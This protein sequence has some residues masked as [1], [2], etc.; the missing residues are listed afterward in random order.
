MDSADNKNTE[1]YYSLIAPFYDRVLGGF[2]DFAIKVMIGH[3]GNWI[4]E[5]EGRRLL[6]IGCG[7]GSFLIRMS[8]YGWIGSG[9]DKSAEMIEIARDKARNT[10]LKFYVRDMRDFNLNGRFDL[11]TCIFDSINYILNINDLREV[12]YNV[13]DHL[14][15]GSYFVF[16]FITPFHGMNFSGVQEESYKDFNFSINPEFDRQ[17]CIKTMN[18]EILYG[19]HRYSEVHKQRCYEIQEVTNLLE[20]TGFRIS[21]TINIYSQTE[22]S[23][24][25]EPTRVFFVVHKI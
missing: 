13:E 6:D 18:I 15:K 24:S 2:E 23:E 9:I 1:T 17:S 7:T 5:G 3:F 19:G 25:S 21:D 11:I 10:E 22:D 16:D 8:Q 4:M 12:F 20:S 14:A